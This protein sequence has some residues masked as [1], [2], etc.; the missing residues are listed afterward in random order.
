M[1]DAT[2]VPDTFAAL[3]AGGR[4]TQVWSYK[5]E[6]R[7]MDAFGRPNS[8]SDCPCERDMQLSVVQS[9]HLMN[10]KNLQSKLSDPAGRI[11]RLAAG[12]RP[13]AGVAEELYLLTLGRPPTAPE[14]ERSTAAFSAEGATRTTATEDIFWAL[15]NSPEFIL[16]H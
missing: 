7:F 12:D 9:L 13:P 5:I 4:A 14:L 6:S 8:S 1:D 2:G 15:V 10:S 16:N 11:H 3:P